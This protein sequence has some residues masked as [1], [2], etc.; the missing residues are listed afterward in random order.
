MIHSLRTTDL[1]GLVHYRMVPLVVTNQHNMLG[2]Y[3]RANQI[4]VLYNS[5]LYSE[6]H[7]VYILRVKQ[8]HLSKG[9]TN[10]GYIQS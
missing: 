3:G 1:E 10:S 6:H 2:T 7:T 5:Q 8:G 9:H 4:K